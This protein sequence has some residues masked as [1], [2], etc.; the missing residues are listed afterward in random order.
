IQATAAYTTTNSTGPYRGAGRPEGVFVIERLM[1]EA[2]HALGLDPADIRRRNLVPA[3]AFPYRTSTGQV[4]DSGNYPAAFERALTLAE[5][6]R[7]RAEQA[8]ARARG[9]V[10]GVGLAAYVEPSAA[11]WESGTVR[12]ERT[13]VVTVVTGSSAHGQGHETTWAQIADLAYRG[14]G[15]P[16]GEAPGLD[17]TVFFNAESE[18]WS[19]GTCVATVAIDRDTGRVTLTRCVWVDDAGTIINPLL[20][21]AQL[22]GSY[23]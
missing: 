10:V 8:R 18:V 4:Y 13:G 14:T 20:A 22:H 23:A 15:L 1:D 9:D 7:Q 16:K 21:E 12:I 17:A 11:G 6:D 19:F 5:Y 3:G 2:A